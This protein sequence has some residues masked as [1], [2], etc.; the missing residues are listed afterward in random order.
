MRRRGHGHGDARAAAELSFYS[1]GAHGG[2]LL[3]LGVG[4]LAR[5]PRTPARPAPPVTDRS[6]VAHTP[7]SRGTRIREGV[8]RVG[9]GTY[10]GLNEHGE[11][12]TA[13]PESAAMILGPP[14]SGKT[15]AVM[16]PALMGCSGAAVSTSTKPDV[17]QATIT[18]RAEIGE[19]WLFDPSGIES[20]P[21]GARRLSW[22]PVRAAATWDGA[23]IVARA[24]T[25]ASRAGVGTTNENH[26]SERASALLAPLLYAAQLT[27][28]PIEEV[29]RSRGGKG[30]CG[31]CPPRRRALLGSCR[32]AVENAGGSRRN[33][34][35]ARQ[36]R[37]RSQAAIV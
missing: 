36:A 33:G 8:L 1:W 14:R 10:L 29:L 23:L 24:M 19:V 31:A 4:V 34:T 16:I 35:A 25:A 32:P 3:T 15:S 11:W 26:W 22:S 5:T 27:E 37:G 7:V 28:R 21:D 12:V 6:A 18:T 17:M 30:P 9:G 2:S 13:A 20:L